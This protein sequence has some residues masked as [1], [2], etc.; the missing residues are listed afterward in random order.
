MTEV[1]QK[2]YKK[3]N[4]KSKWH[5]GT[6]IHK[7]EKTVLNVV[8]TVCGRFMPLKWCSQ[9]STDT[10]IEVCK[11][12]ISNNNLKNGRTCGQLS[13]KIRLPL[14]PKNFLIQI[15]NKQYALIEVVVEYDG[16]IDISVL[17]VNRNDFPNKPVMSIDNVKAEI[18]CLELYSKELYKQYK[19]NGF[20]VAPGNF[21]ITQK[22]I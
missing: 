2:L 7:H 19:Q 4:V 6:A 11:V 8:E 12:C 14:K 3:I 13:G 18:R 17:G 16:E 20:K 21:L 10:D 22:G 5:I 15:Y 9:P 1:A